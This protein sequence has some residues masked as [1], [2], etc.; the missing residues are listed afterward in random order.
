MRTLQNHLYKSSGECVFLLEGTEGRVL[1]NEVFDKV[2]SV[3]DMPF[4]WRRYVHYVI[5]IFS[6]FHFHSIVRFCEL[7]YDPLRNYS[8]PLKY[9]R[10]L[11]KIINV[12]S[13]VKE[14]QNRRRKHSKSTLVSTP[15][16]A[17]VIRNFATALNSSYRN[18][19][20]CRRTWTS[21]N[22]RDE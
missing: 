4:T 20:H 9:T 6:Y 3:D 22:K 18:R 11:H 19:C 10:A 16:T 21:T 7:L 8:H 13:T 14:C 15:V 12:V 2:R 1:L 5:F 17:V